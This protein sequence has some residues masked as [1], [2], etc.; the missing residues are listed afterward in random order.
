MLWEEKLAENQAGHLTVKQEIVPFD[1]RTDRAGDQGAAQLPAMLGFGEAACG[2]FGCRHRVPPQGCQAYK[3]LPVVVLPAL[4]REAFPHALMLSERKINI[5]QPAGPE[6]HKETSA[7]RSING[8]FAVLSYIL[9][10]CLYLIGCVERAL[11]SRNR[12]YNDTCIRVVVVKLGC[13]FPR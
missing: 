6:A 12:N 5:K 2:N 8:A 3:E 10:R 7:V 4:M 13:P 9:C 11:F 1:C